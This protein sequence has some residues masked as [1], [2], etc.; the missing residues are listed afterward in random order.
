VP[1]LGGEDK[2]VARPLFVTLFAL[3]LSLAL[4]LACGAIAAEPPD[5]ADPTK[6]TPTAAEEPATKAAP[7]EPVP[8][9]AHVTIA[10][11]GDSLADGIWGGVFRK[12][13]QN[14]KLTVYR[15]AKNSVGFGSGDLLDMIEQAFAAGPVDAVVMMVGA[16]DRRGIHRADGSVIAPYRSPQWPEA[17]KNRVEAFMDGVTS[18]GVPMVWILL[19]VM[20]EDDAS[21]DAKQM[22]AIVTAAAASR[23]KVTL[24][25]TWP[26]TIDGD[27]AFNA[28]LKDAKGQSR[29][30]RAPDGIHFSDAGYDMIA[31][32]VVAKVMDVSAPIRLV[33]RSK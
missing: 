9:P 15:G 5:V 19:P 25:E 31:E 16:N 17:Y 24:I 2:T 11:L 6:P 4:S 27:G 3:I 26:M 7:A 22:N 28:Y 30:V 21:A 13:F 1:D 23:P 20:R 18:R 29:L 14:K 32:A 12:Y 33:L 10:V 8:V